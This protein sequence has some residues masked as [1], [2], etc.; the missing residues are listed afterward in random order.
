MVTWHGMLLS[1]GHMMLLSVPLSPCSCRTL[2]S[3]PGPH[4]PCCVRNPAARDEGER[5]IFHQHWKKASQSPL[6][7]SS[8]PSRPS[9]HH[10]V[11]NPSS[12]QYLKCSAFLILCSFCIPSPLW[13]VVSFFSFILPFYSSN[14][15]ILLFSTHLPPP[16]LPSLPLS[17]PSPSLLPSQQKDLWGCYQGK[18]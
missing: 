13:H 14:L 18:V 1:L 5:G 9:I 10:F 15:F 16:L 11:T 3:C 7:A 4:E 8:P 12:L 2:W 17:P 6:V